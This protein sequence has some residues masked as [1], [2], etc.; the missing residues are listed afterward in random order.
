MHAFKAIGAYFVPTRCPGDIR[1]YILSG[2]R[3]TTV[4][5]LMPRTSK[6]SSAYLRAYNPVLFEKREPT[7]AGRLEIGVRTYE[8]FNYNLYLK[9]IANFRNFLQFFQRTR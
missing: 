1:L 4:P 2:K 5:R 7:Q 6:I 8:S 9:S 3:L